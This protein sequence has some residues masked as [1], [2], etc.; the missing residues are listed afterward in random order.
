V[1]GGMGLNIGIGLVLSFSYILFMTVTQTFALNG[2]TSPLIAMWIPNFL[3]I[4][5]AVVLYMRAAK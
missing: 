3:Y 5:I 4:I 1:K 2:L